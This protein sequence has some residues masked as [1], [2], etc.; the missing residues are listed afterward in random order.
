MVQPH[1]TDDPASEPLGGLLRRLD[2]LQ[3]ELDAIDLDVN[4]NARDTRSLVAAMGVSACAGNPQ[5]VGERFVKLGVLVSRG[6]TTHD[7]WLELLPA[8]EWRDREKGVEVVPDQPFA[9]YVPR[10]AWERRY[11]P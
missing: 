7:T 6:M 1:T 9:E 2:A 11:R 5:L 10:E 8:V 3:P 4:L